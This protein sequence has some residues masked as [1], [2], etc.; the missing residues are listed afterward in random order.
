[1][2]MLSAFVF[3]AP[4][5]VF[6]LRKKIHIMII[7]IILSA[8]PLPYCRS[9]RPS[10]SVSDIIANKMPALQAFGPSFENVFRLIIPYSLGIML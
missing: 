7:K 6:P 5:L 8:Y 2:S 1:M 3:F 4:P 10:D 9:G